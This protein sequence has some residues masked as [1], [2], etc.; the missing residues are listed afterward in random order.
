[1]AAWDALAEHLQDRELT[2]LRDSER[3]STTG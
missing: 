1:M 3:H 2:R